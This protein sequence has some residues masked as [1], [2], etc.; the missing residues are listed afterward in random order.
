MKLGRQ[1]LAC[2]ARVAAGAFLAGIVLVGCGGS[3]TS[4]TLSDAQFISQANAACKAGA[5]ATTALAVPTDVASTAKY[6]AN[7]VPIIQKYERQL[8][9]LVAPSAKQKEYKRMLS[10]MQEE[11]AQLSIAGKA[12][13][14]RDVQK[15]QSIY[16]SAANLNKL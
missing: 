1:H 13:A 15:V 9:A 14:A 3:G 12:A 10:L 8:A 4:G 6:I 2:K 11:I 16:S 5:S 7:A